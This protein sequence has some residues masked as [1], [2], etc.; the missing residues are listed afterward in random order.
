MSEAEERL[1]WQL[2]SRDGLRGLLRET[3][4]EKVSH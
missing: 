3:H 2:V 4:L 1:D